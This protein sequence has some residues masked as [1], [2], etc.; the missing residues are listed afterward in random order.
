MSSRLLRSFVLISL[1]VCVLQAQGLSQARPPLAIALM[2]DSEVATTKASDK[3][4][5]DPWIGLNRGIFAFNSA[6]D[7]NA[8]RPLAVA[9]RSLTWSGLRRGLSNAFSNLQEPENALWNLLQGKVWKALVCVFRFVI[10][11]TIGLGG[12]LDPAAE[13]GL[14][15]APEDFGQTLGVWGLSPGAY[16]V[17]PFLGPSSLRDS[18]GLL[19]DYGVRYYLTP[20]QGIQRKNWVFILSLL[21]TRANLL[22]VDELAESYETQR[23]AW[24]SRREYLVRDGMIELQPLGE[25]EEE[26]LDFLDEFDEEEFDELEDDI[27]E[28]AGQTGE[29][30]QVFV[31]TRQR[32]SHI[33]LPVQ[34]L[35]IERR[36]QLLYSE[37]G[38]E[39]RLRMAMPLES[40][41]GLGQRPTKSAEILVDHQA[42]IWQ[43]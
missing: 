14:R 41:Y 12:F 21:S 7:R 25:E 13:I 24:L 10:N 17:I 27:D 6:I 19:G 31:P 30:S 20:T 8:L 28:D 42:R 9:Y 1:A 16:T 35:T 23:D 11:S 2:T 36:L 3:N 38:L 34:L 43:S 26:L 33:S 39:V 5:Q 40:I 37:I 29:D 4:P 22:G 15:P 18:F 32:I